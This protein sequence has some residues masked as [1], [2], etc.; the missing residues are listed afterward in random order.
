MRIDDLTAKAGLNDPPLS[1]DPAL[2]AR[3]GLSFRNAPKRGHI[4]SVLHW[5]FRKIFDVRPC[6]NDLRHDPASTRIGQDRRLI[7]GI[8]R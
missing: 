4:Q 5:R 7:V 8:A 1:F 2:T 3:Y 6:I